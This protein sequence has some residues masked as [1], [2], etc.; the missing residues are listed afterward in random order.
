MNDKCGLVNP[1]NPCR[2]A[3]KTRGFIA[4]GYVDPKNLRFASDHVQR[5]REVIGSKAEA[6]SALHVRCGEVFREHPFYESPNLVA[7][8]RRLL[9]S[10]EFTHATGDQA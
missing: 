7:A 5:V 9:A 10:A 6:L 4:A 1:S 3:R 2:C 8:L